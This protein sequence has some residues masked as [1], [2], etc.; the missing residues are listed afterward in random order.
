MVYCCVP[1]CRSDHRKSKNVSFHE[2]PCEETVKERWIKN[3]RRKD[4]SGK[5]WRPADRSVV[6]SRHFEKSAFKEGYKKRILKKDSTPTVF[7]DYPKCIVQ[8]SQPQRGQFKKMKLSEEIGIQKN[9]TNNCYIVKDS[10]QMLA[11]VCSAVDMRQKTHSGSKNILTKQASRNKVLK[12]DESLTS[13][14]LVPCKFSCL[15]DR[16]KLLQESLRVYKLRIKAI[17]QENEVMR[18]LI[19]KSTVGGN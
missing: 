11:E 15:P 13:E 19:L 8:S 17:K 12:T 16:V 1:Y 9:D 6:C 18:K 4:S 7:E 5:L 3:I 14:K 10:L 2:F